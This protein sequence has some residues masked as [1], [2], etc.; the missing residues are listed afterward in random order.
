MERRTLLSVGALTGAVAVLAL[1]F[2]HAPR[3]VAF[4]PRAPSDPGEVLEARPLGANDERTREIAGLRRTLATAPRDLPRAVRLARLD[5][6]LARE[7]S[8]PRYLGHAQAALAPW[9]SEETPP[10]EVLVLRATI[11]QSLHDFEAALRDLDRAVAVAPDHVQAWLTRA[12]VLGV[13][14]RYAEASESCRRLV[15]LTTN[16][17]ATVC[18]S[19]IDSVTGHAAEASTRLTEALA[20]AGRVSPD[21]EAWA[22]SSLGEYATRLGKLDD[23]EREL[24]RTLE[25]DSNDSYARAALADLLLDRGR[26]KEALALVRGK[27]ANDTLLLRI[28]VAERR[29]GS[30]DAK[31]HAAALGARFDASRLR[32]DVVHRREEA[33]YWLEVEGDAA[34]ALPLALANWDVQK[35]PADLRILLET[36]LAARRPGD[37]AAVLAWLSETKLEDPFIAKTAEAL[38]AALAKP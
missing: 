31:S 3:A 27:E 12:V 8:D 15:P 4:A 33:R 21:E 30:P 20:R 9:W 17:V 16:L 5:I 7:R 26:P 25:L 24:A 36:A 11:L 34:R 28:A 19:G 22:R 6:M 2:G 10:V 1:L 23:A 37:A 18:Q 35:E 32:G 29:L 14:G 13:R 38:R